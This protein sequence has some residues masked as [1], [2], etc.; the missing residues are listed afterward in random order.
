MPKENMPENDACRQWRENAGL[1]RA[2]LAKLSGWSIS[3][4]QDFERGT[5]HDGRPLSDAAWQRYRLTCAA[6][7]RGLYRFA[8]DKPPKTK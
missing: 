5:K 8:W 1:T 7:S 6:I 3:Q 2:Q 4:I